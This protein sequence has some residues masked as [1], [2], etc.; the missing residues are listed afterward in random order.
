MRILARVNEEI[1][2]L[3]KE[4]EQLANTQ[5][6]ETTV[7]RQIRGVG[8]ITAMTFL[9]TLD[10]PRRFRSS[11]QVAAYLGLVPKLRESGDTGARLRITKAGDSLLRRF[12]VHCAH[13][14]LG[15]L[16]REEC[17]LVLWA[18]E[19]MRRGGRNAKERAVVAVGRKL[20]VRLH[21]VW[22]TGEVYE[23][24]R[25]QPPKNKLEVV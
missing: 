2:R 23:P 12:L 18:R 7:L 25:N 5:Y 6:P 16:N 24:C 1:N 11:R 21:R 9:V 20:A 4:I 17:D 19:Y 8:P 15:P 14:V 10:D 3:D 13:Y 22:L